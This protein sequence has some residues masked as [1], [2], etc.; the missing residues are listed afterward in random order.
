MGTKIRTIDEDEA[1]ADVDDLGENQMSMTEA[2]RLKKI[3]Y[4]HEKRHKING[5]SSSGRDEH[6]SSVQL[7]TNHH[8]N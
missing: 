1:E 7:S 6:L 8:L 4:F 3:K 5:Y 2:Q